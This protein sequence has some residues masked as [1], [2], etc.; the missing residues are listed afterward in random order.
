MANLKASTVNGVLT[1]SSISGTGQTVPNSYGA[2]LHLGTWAD[3]RTAT[4]TVLVN[5]AYRADYATDLFDMNISRFTN[6]SG[7]ITANGA[8]GAD[9]NFYIDDN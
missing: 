7:Y 9:G 5:T 6:N 2:Y 4:G 8:T 1:L 3:G